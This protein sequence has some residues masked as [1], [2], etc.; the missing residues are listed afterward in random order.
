MKGKGLSGRQVRSTL[1]FQQKSED[2]RFANHPGKTMTGQERRKHPRFNFK[3]APIRVRKDLSNTGVSLNISF[4]GLGRLKFFARMPK[5]EVIT[6]TGRARLPRSRE[7]NGPAAPAIRFPKK[8]SFPGRIHHA[9][10]RRSIDSRGRQGRRSG[11]AHAPQGGDPLLQ[12]LCGVVG[13]GR[14]GAGSCR[15]SIPR[16]SAR[17]GVAGLV[18]GGLD[19][20]GQPHAWPD[21]F[22]LPHEKIGPP[23]P[24]W[25]IDR[26]GRAKPLKNL[27]TS[28]GGGS[29]HCGW[30]AG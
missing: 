1:R 3:G 15:D 11:A 23:S 21:R 27:L 6:R 14:C 30:K 29:G 12:I 25:G 22:G 26:K 20:D 8:T 19:D 2:K 9:Q 4:G 7:T 13:G 16:R 18:A 17:A 24:V 5:R 10:S 28:Q